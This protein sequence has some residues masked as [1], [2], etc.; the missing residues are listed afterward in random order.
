[1]A[2][3]TQAIKMLLHVYAL[4]ILQEVMNV[5]IPLGTCERSYR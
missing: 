3:N 1:M 2:T 5:N 4:D